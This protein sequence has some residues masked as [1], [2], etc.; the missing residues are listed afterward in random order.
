M[1]DHKA[2]KEKENVNIFRRIK[3]TFR[4]KIGWNNLKMRYQLR[5]HLFGLFGLFFIL[6]FI[7][8]IAYTKIQYV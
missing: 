2:Y 7:F 8:M 6:Y 3:R 5:V 4:K 1:Q